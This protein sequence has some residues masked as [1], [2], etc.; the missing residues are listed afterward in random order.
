[1]YTNRLGDSDGWIEN[2]TDTT[3]SLRMKTKNY[4]NSC[5]VYGQIL[6]LLCG[7][8]LCHLRLIVLFTVD[9]AIYGYCA[10]NGLYN[11]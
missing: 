1:M 9:F 8:R 10:I 6:I 2:H 5:A 3:Y 7:L 4:P 11:I